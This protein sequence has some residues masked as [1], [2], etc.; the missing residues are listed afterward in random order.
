MGPLCV[1]FPFAY[2]SIERDGGGPTSLRRGEGHWVGFSSIVGSELG[3]RR[4]GGG[5]KW[6]DEPSINAVDA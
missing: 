4:G 6:E 3:W 1:I 2:S 5:G